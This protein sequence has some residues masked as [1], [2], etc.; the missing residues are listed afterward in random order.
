MKG[1]RY[2]V[3]ILVALLLSVT[4]SVAACAQEAIPEQP[5]A[6]EE[7]PAGEQPIAPEEQPMMPEE[8]PAPERFPMDEAIKAALTVFPEAQAV[9]AKFSDPLFGDAVY[10]IELSNGMEVKVDAQT[11]EVLGS[12]ELSEPSPAVTL[13]PQTTVPLEQAVRVALSTKQDRAAVE[14]KLVEEESNIV[15][16][17]KLDNGEEIRVDA[18]LTEEAPAEEPTTEVEEQ[19]EEAPAEETPVEEPVF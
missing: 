16:V 19:S 18:A 12:T 2:L 7:A 1:N 6:P 15:Y 4:F 10:L 5:I 17:I 14:A 9:S 11:G 8:P 3:G 13:L